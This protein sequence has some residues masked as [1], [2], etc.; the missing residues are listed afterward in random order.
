MYSVV[1]LG[2]WYPH[3]INFNGYVDVN[4]LTEERRRLRNH[5]N[6]PP[7]L[8]GLYKR[9]IQDE[10]DDVLTCLEES[11]EF[12]MRVNTLKKG[13]HDIRRI[14]RER[15]VKLKPLGWFRCRL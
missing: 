6:L 5:L 14:A 4:Y 9:L 7:E 1:N 8:L 11:P 15:G 13:V 10:V 12:F 2:P 3:N